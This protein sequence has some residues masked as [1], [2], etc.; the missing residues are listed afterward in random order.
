MHAGCRCLVFSPGYTSYVYQYLYLQ[1]W[2]SGTLGV[3]GPPVLGRGM[4][5]VLR[6]TT[7]MS[8]PHFIL[9]PVHFVT[10]RMSVFLHHGSSWDLGRGFK[11]GYGMASQLESGR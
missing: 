7:Y 3:W 4:I 11:L 1:G 9:S 6:F 10:L 5:Y 2:G 8:F